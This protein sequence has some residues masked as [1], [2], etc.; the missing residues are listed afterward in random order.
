VSSAG[1]LLLN[2]FFRTLARIF[3]ISSSYI[4]RKKKKQLKEISDSSQFLRVIETPTKEAS[5]IPTTS[6]ESKQDVSKDVENRRIIDEKLLKSI[7]ELVQ[8][9]ETFVKDLEKLMEQYVIP[10]QLTYLECTEKLIKTHSI[11][12]TSLQDASGDLLTAS[13][14]LSLNYTQIKDAVMRIAALFINKCN[15]FKIYSEYSAAYLRFQ[16]LQKADDKLKT[17]LEELNASGQHKESVQSLLIKPIQRVLKYPL[18]LEQI[19]DFCTKDSMEQKQCIQALNRMQTLATYV[20]EMQRI[21][22]E[23]G[24]ELERLAKLPELEEK[25]LW[26][27][28]RDLFMFAH[29]RWI[30]PGEKKY[31]DCVAF[32]FM[33][34][35]L[36]LGPQTIGKK[37]NKRIH[38]IF[39]IWEIEANELDSEVTSLASSLT[40][41]SSQH[42]FTIT[43][44][45]P[46]QNEIVYP[47]S[48][49]HVDIKTHFIKSVKKAL[50]VY[51]KQKPRPISGSSQSDW[52][53]SSAH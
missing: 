31:T 19:K 46:S 20:N 4:T 2:G 28:L 25:N 5:P 23:Y 38:K 37:G 39:P 24:S 44:L 43:H 17:K 50:R 53:Y 7:I 8:T 3:F 22:E 40:A 9:E 34:L 12:L 13:S 49:C 18:F 11:F 6:R 30:L 32:V 1:T 21:H 35:V 36:I 52:G 29:L 16:H 26:M 14:S 51:L 33:S 42:Y 47:I 48:C 41:D 45:G 27:D 15:K 10:G